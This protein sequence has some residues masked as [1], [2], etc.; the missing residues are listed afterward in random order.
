MLRGYR[1]TLQM[2]QNRLL[3]QLD[4]CS[5]VLQR[6]NLQEDFLN[7]FGSQEELLAFYT[8]AT[9]ITRYGNYRTF[10]IEEIDFS[11]SPMSTFECKGIFI[12]Y[13]DYFRKVYNVE[14][15]DPKQP[16]L[17]VISRINKFISKDQLMKEDSSYIYLVP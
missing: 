7:F 1:L 3:L 15:S 14:I 16:L 4:V 5:R 11:L 13:I 9:V 10:K 17:K 6:S 8:G 2:M 12:S